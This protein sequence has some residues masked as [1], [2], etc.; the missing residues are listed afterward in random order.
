MKDFALYTL[1]LISLNN[2]AKSVILLAISS[3]FTTGCSSL[4]YYP[5]QDL[6]YDPSKLNLNPKDLWIKD[7]NYQIHAW[8]FK[9]ENS[10][11]KG[12]FVF[13]H[14]NAENLTSH[15]LS[16]TWLL[17][18][19]YDFIIFDYPGYGQSSGEP[20]PQSTVDSGKLVLNWIH[21]NIDQ[22]PLIIYGNSLGGIVSLRAVE[23]LKD[24]IP[25][26]IFIVDSSFDSYKKIG[27]RALSRTWITW[28]FQPLAYLLLNDHFAPS[29]LSKLAPI[30]LLF[31]H[32]QKDT[33]V[34]PIF[35]EEM[36][37]KAAQPKELWL[38]PKGTHGSTFYINNG[39]Y[40]NRLI[41]FI[42]KIDLNPSTHQ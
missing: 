33:V 36:Y 14:G 21:N 13:F 16:L 1:N 27:R 17:D 19:H 28:L 20:S 32:G 15:Y 6:L 3:F 2:L 12:T 11:S 39:E 41:D 5:K 26:K 24:Q 22:R 29:D 40:R 23:D 18:Y 9:N 35:S 4:F 25:I 7:A 34:E 37:S 8:H 31:I 30:P 42:E 38:I 10:Q